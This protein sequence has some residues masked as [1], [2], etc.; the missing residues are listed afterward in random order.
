[1]NASYV[2]WVCL[3][4]LLL[5]IVWTTNEGADIPNRKLDLLEAVNFNQLIVFLVANNLTGAINLT[6]K[7]IYM[8]DIESLIIITG[9]MFLLS[10]FALILYYRRWRIKFW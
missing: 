1:M 3:H 9:Y 4:D 10:A 7:T 6:F 2:F 5:L 8:S